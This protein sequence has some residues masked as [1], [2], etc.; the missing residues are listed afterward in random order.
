MRHISIGRAIVSAFLFSILA[1]SPRWVS[2]QGVFGSITGVVTDPSGAVV[3]HATVKAINVDTGVVTTLKT[4]TEG[5]YNAS[6]LNP[7]L[8]NVQ[9]EVAGFK[10]A[11]ASGIKVDVGASPR[12]NLALQVGATSESVTVEA[13]TAGLKTEQSNL[14]QTVT[15]R[16]LQDLPV[17]SSSGRSIWNLVPLSVG[18]TQ[19][20]GG[21]GYAL[22]NMRI[23]GGRPRM[24]DYLVD[25]TSV[26]A[27]VFGGPVVGPSV[28]SI[29]QFT[30]LTNSFS[31]E[32]GKV[33]G[34]VISAVTKTGTN[35]FH[36]SAYEY[37]KNNDL[38]ARNFFAASNLPLRY[39]EFGATL[40]GPVLKDSLFFFVDYQGIRTSTSSPQVNYLVPSVAFRNGDLSALTAKL[41]DPAASQPFA[42]NQVP[43]SPIAQKLLQM[44]P[45]GNGGPSGQPGVDYWSGTSSSSN[46]VNRFNPRVDWN[47]RNGD[48]IFGVYH[49]ERLSNNNSS[50][51]GGTV[52]GASFG[53]S[54]DY[55]VTVGWTHTLNAATVNDFRFGASHHDAL[56]TTNGYGVSSDADFGIEGFPVCNLP[57]SNGKCGAPTI[58]IGGYTGVGGGGGMLAEPSGQVQFT[59]TLSKVIGR[60]TLKI[61]GEIRLARIDNIQ[62][63]QLTGNFAF[64]GNGTG[65]AFA[66]FL[67]GYLS[68]S[69]AQVQTDYLKT[70]GR[71]DALFVQDDFK[72][73]RRLTLNLG[74]RWQYDPSFT[75]PLNQ[76]A[77]FN[78]YTL[79]WEQN[80]INAPA[81]AIDTHWR[82]FAPRVG[83]AFNPWSGFVVRGGFGM[84]Y[85]GYWGHGR[86]GDAAASPNVLA[87]TQ[88]NPGTYISDLP[89][90]VLPQVNAPLAVWQ[91]SYATYTPRQ[92]PVGYVEQ[93]NFTVEK[94]VGNTFIQAAYTGSHGVH[95]PVQY[96]YNVCQQS[97]ANV[98]QYG[99]AAADMD[100]PYCGPGNSAAL[101][102]LYGDYV[103]PGWWGIAS[104][105]YHALQTKVERRYSNGLSFLASFTWS[106]LIDNSSSDWSGFGSLDI[107]GT[108]FYNLQNA[109]SVSAGNVPLRL[110][111]SPIYE[112]P[113]GAGKRWLNNGVASE[114]L[115]GWRVSAIYTASSG[116]PIGV[117]DLGY[118]Y[119]NAA[120]M[121]NVQ[122]TMI[123]NPLPSG[124]QQT[125]DHWFNTA[126]FDWSGTCVYSSGLIQ[127]AGSANPA[128]T[129]GN[130]PRYFSDLHNP[131]VNNLDFSLQKEFKVPIGEQGRL[132]FQADAFNALNHTQFGFPD[133]YPDG[134]FGRIS[135]TRVPGRIIQL[136]LHLYF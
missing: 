78:P 54:H 73:T 7:G 135:S 116:E 60:H 95:L 118:Q 46:P 99:L 43:V 106:K 25:G 32:Y 70:R 15:N 122:P 132:R 45:V 92:Q 17:Q 127:T 89:A 58:S 29:E 50:P 22:N 120:R 53:Y 42:N 110:V 11:V 1:L 35:Q 133:S 62:P 69:S 24:D 2:A 75:S 64:N 52:A 81:G 80:G 68:K 108:D 57:E 114:A 124:F 94:Q 49:F 103:Y 8:Y 9:A 76:T 87:P 28:D 10:T 19:Q 38:D 5:V 101:G 97:A 111:I 112:L 21:G 6:S 107:P 13:P 123:G 105:I 40:G 31:A 47:A 117:T 74:L 109:R 48:H 65:N 119:C 55:A 104:S 125:I 30:V 82:E 36:G 12:V 102:G 126:A 71:S 98:A 66:D 61:G 39:N 41:V 121:Y 83:F 23:N 130:A 85:P 93:W 77:S 44:Y 131:M 128:Y 59:D 67:I 18:V 27:V 136:G 96:S 14:S 91:G 56:R 84:T 115:G 79:E 33:S 100:T 88:I 134:N 72:L 51:F 129:Y 34:G 90:L 86:A 4:N 16:Q 113:I 26:E 63:N 20:I 37:F 3:P